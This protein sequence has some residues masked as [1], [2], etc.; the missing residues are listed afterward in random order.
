LNQTAVPPFLPKSYPGTSVSVPT[1]HEA[2]G[3]LAER[4]MH[5]NKTITHYCEKVNVLSEPDPCTAEYQCRDIQNAALAASKL[6]K[7]RE[8]I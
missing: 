8:M 6:R 1:P 2:K 7:T 4:H 5:F 3:N